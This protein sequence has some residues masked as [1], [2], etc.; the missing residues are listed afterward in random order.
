MLSAA[1][2]L[3]VAA[4]NLVPRVVARRPQR[5]VGLHG[6]P[7]DGPAL[8]LAMRHRAVLLALVGVLLAIA[9]FDDPWLR[10]ALLVAL[11]SKVSF[12]ALFATTRPHGAPMRR[13]ALA[14]VA[15]LEVLALVVALRTR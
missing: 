14:D 4:L 9:A 10:R 3:L 7:I 5:T 8:A 11:L 15:A 1:L 13:V 2:R 6:F 12:L